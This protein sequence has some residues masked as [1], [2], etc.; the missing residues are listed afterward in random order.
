MI[1]ACKKFYV[2]FL[3]FLYSSLLFSSPI[4]KMK[5]LNILLK[6]CSMFVFVIENGC[7]MY[8][9]RWNKCWL[10][11]W[12]HA[13]ASHFVCI[14]VEYIV[15]HFQAIKLNNPLWESNLWTYTNKTC[16]REL[17]DGHQF[18]FCLPIKH[19]SIPCFLTHALL[20]SNNFII[21][22]VYLWLL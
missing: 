16:S 5:H 11:I 3:R 6:F 20:I 10:L 13:I 15:A 4:N 2:R 8:R 21:V 14:T 9:K 19:K 1:L 18:F 12:R 22:S 7:Q 17:N